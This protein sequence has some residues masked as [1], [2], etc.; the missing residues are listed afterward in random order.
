M[1]VVSW[2]L[3]V[4]GLDAAWP[5]PLQFSFTGVMHMP[6]APSR[7]PK[8]NTREGETT[9]LSKTTRKLGVEVI[10]SDTLPREGISSLA[11]TQANHHRTKYVYICPTK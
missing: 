2:N 4:H 11:A 7:P 6:S 5:M 1:E 8:M 9:G 3:I 10:A